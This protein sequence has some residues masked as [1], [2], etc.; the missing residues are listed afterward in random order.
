MGYINID[1]GFLYQFEQPTLAVT[2][3][4]A[5][6]TV[7]ELQEV[8]FDSSQVKNAYAKYPFAKPED[9]DR[10]FNFTLEDHHKARPPAMP[11]SST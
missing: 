3:V 1:E 9:Y 6:G 7:F 2:G 8:P 11:T 4:T 10:T 5:L